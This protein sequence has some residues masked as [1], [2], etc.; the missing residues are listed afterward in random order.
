MTEP[1]LRSEGE[2]LRVRKGAEKGIEDREGQRWRRTL[3]E[4]GMQERQG[5]GGTTHC[6]REGDRG[7]QGCGEADQGQ[8][9]GKQGSCLPRELGWADTSLG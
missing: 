2:K 1:R 6:R 9:G 4:A 7:S 3:M 5:Q 8:G